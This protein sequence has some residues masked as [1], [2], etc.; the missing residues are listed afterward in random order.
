MRGLWL[1]AILGL[2]TVSNAGPSWICSMCQ[3]AVNVVRSILASDIL[4][5]M[6]VSYQHSGCLQSHTQKY[7]DDEAQYLL[8]PDYITTWRVINA[9]EICVKISLCSNVQY[10][11]DPDPVY[12]RR[13]LKDSPPVTPRSIPDQSKVLKFVVMTDPHL[14]FGYE[15]VKN[16]T[17]P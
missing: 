1:V 7:C 17:Q 14:D 10:L 4:A 5:D 11:A 6:F 16:I 2:V 3:G 13:V 9:E 12:V 8:K 15:E